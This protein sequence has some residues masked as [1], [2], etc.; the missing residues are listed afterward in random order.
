MHS[1]NQL[2]QAQEIK[3][4]KENGGGGGGTPYV[5]PTASADTKGGVKIGNGLTMTGQVLSADAQIPAGDSGDVGKVLTKYGEN[6]NQY[7]WVQSQAAYTSYN[8]SISGLN[9]E[10]VQMAIDEL[11]QGG[12]GGGSNVPDPTSNDENKFLVATYDDTTEMVVPVWG[13]GKANKVRYSGDIGTS[14]PSNVKYV[15]EALD[16]LDQR[17]KKIV[18]N[19]QTLVPYDSTDDVYKLTVYDGEDIFDDNKPAKLIGVDVNFATKLSNGVVS[20]F[21]VGHVE[22]DPQ[23]LVNTGYREADAENAVQAVVTIPVSRVYDSTNS[24]TANADAGS[25]LRAYINFNTKDSDVNNN[26]YS[27]VLAGLYIEAE[28]KVGGQYVDD[29]TAD[30]S[31]YVTVYKQLKKTA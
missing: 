28:V 14:F 29:I 15:N 4:L 25:H 27:A 13:N 24:V 31:L 17:S 23:Y 7:G 19:A 18:L 12:S 8:N 16:V 6:A 10:N 30:G 1:L 22:F 2:K 20:E 9:A 5:L 21:A 3:E 11:A 26:V